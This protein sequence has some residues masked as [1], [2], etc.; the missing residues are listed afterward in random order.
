MFES[1][2]PFLQVAASNSSSI[3]TDAIISGLAQQIGSSSSSSNS[4]NGVGG[5][6]TASVALGITGI[7]TGIGAAVKTLFIDKH[8]KTNE[9]ETDFDNEKFR[10]LVNIENNYALKF[11]EKTRA[12]ILNLPVYPDQPA[13]NKTLAQAFAEDYEDYKKYN[14]KTY[15]QKK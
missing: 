5:G 11:P 4:A 7:A 2:L 10:E 14:I 1:F 6:D 13:I 8:Q 9:K 3:P 12:E 15:Y